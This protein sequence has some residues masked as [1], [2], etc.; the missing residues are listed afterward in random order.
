MSKKQNP[1]DSAAQYYLSLEQATAKTTRGASVSLLIICG[2]VLLVLGAFLCLLP[3][4]TFSPEENRSLAAFPD[5][6]AE[7]I[8]DGSFAGGIADFC[9][10][11]FP[12][13]NQFVALKAGV[14]LALGKGQNNSVILGKDGYLIKYPQYTEEQWHMMEQNVTAAARFAQAMEKNDIPFSFYVV[15]R[16]VD[17]NTERLPAVFDTDGLERDRERLLATAKSDG[18]SVHDLTQTLRGLSEQNNIWYKT[19]HHWTMTGAYYA[20]VAL[21]DSLGYAPYPMSD[22]TPVTV[23][24]SFLGTTQASSGMT[25]IPGEALTLL[26]YD[27]DEDFRTEI[28]SG[29]QTV[30]TLNGFYD[31]DALRTH[32]EYNVFLGGTNTIIRVSH[33]QRK[34]A[35]KLVLLKDSFSQSLAPLL[36]RHFDLLLV[37]PRTYS[38]Q[39]GSILSLVQN[40]GADR[41]LLLYGLDTLYDSYSLNKLIFGLK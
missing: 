34:D 20:Y 6:S 26:R 36:A 7:A 5:C 41:V 17:I 28:I 30:R 23:C 4:K 8:L 35:P 19:D 39:S 14:E 13:R 15:P 24:D 33:P 1:A 25:W 31:F 29:G 2:A 22:F 11:Q 16:S 37:D 21:A 3:K 32:D 12:L 40:E 9:A 18:L 27:G 38:V 10:D